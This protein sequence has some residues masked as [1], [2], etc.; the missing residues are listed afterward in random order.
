MGRL[1]IHLAFQLWSILIVWV[2]FWTWNHRGL[3]LFLNYNRSIIVTYMG[4]YFNLK[5]KVRVY[6]LFY[7]PIMIHS[8]FMGRYFNLKPFVGVYN[9]FSFQLCSLSGYFNLKRKVRIYSFFLHS[10]YDPFWLYMGGH[11]NLKCKVE[12]FNS[13]SFQLWSI[14]VLW[15]PN[16]IWIQ[17]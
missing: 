2:V 13:F 9:S 10:N 17:V 4:D 11:F 6:S 8:S 16:W 3:Q 7:I 5:P 15:A 1:A 14:M 12:I